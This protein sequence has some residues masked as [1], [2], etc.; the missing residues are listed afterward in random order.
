[1]DFQLVE[2]ASIAMLFI[3]FYGLTISRNIIRSIIFTVLM[4][5]SVILFFLGIGF[6]LRFNGMIPPVGPHI[7]EMDS[8]VYV[9]DPLPQA[10]M[11]TAIVIGMSVTAVNIVM[12]LT[13]LRKFKTA[14][15][16]RV[17]DKSLGKA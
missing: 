13:L 5:S 4:E 9:A 14:D 12:L 8:L 6:R 7:P 2:I 15:W 17:R 1:M 3:S 16:D 10:L 11:L